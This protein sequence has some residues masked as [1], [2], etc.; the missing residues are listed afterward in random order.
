LYALAFLGTNTAA[1]A[2]QQHWFVGSSNENVAFS[3]GSDTEAYAGHLGKARELTRQ[4]VSAAIR[5]DSKE[6][7]AVWEENAA[8]RE[9]GFGNFAESTRAAAEGLKLTPTSQGVQIEA[10]LAFAMSGDAAHAQS[11]SSDLNQRSPLD[12]Q[13]QSLWIPTIRAQLALNAKNPAQA[14]QELQVAAPIE[15]GQIGFVANISCLYP[16][17]VRGEAY[18]ASGD[19]GAAAA[20]FQKIL[21]HNGIVWNCWTGALARL[22]I[23]R[24]NALE[25]KS[26][27]GADADAARGRAAASYKEFLTLWKNADPEIPILKEAKAEY[28]QLQ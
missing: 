3:L 23:A 16:V 9:A 2:E 22:G 11:I 19:G 8:L 21:D 18:L 26:S 17:Y 13:V 27:Q 25:A 28:A 15:L 1:M 5:A 4:A 12:T 10:G 7:G 24:A 6:N 14:I 20:E